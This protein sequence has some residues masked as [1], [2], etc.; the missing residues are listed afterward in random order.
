MCD[1]FPDGELKEEHREILER[2]LNRCKELGELEPNGK[3]ISI[4]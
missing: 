2:E 3:C 4:F 1:H